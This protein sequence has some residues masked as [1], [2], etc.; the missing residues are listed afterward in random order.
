M[1]KPFLDW[2]PVLGT[3]ANSAYSVQKKTLHLTRVYTV[4]KNLFVKYNKGEN[5]H[6]KPI[7]L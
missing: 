7:K 3:Y 1:P 2:I 5:I 6:Q 4:Y